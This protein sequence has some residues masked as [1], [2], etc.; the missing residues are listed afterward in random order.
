MARL[1]SKFKIHLTVKDMLLKPSTA[2]NC[3]IGYKHAQ[4]STSVYIP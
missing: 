4:N 2:Q 3:L 1:Q